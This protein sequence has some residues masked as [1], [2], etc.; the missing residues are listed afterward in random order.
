MTDFRL[1]CYLA[2]VWLLISRVRIFKHCIYPERCRVG[3]ILETTTEPYLK[4]WRSQGTPETT[5]VALEL[6]PLSSEP[7][8]EQDYWNYLQFGI[9]PT[10]Q[11]PLFFIPAPSQKRSL[12][13]CDGSGTMTVQHQPIALI[14]D[15][16]DRWGKRSQLVPTCI[17]PGSLVDTTKL[18]LAIQ[19]VSH[20]DQLYAIEYGDRTAEI[21]VLKIK[22]ARSPNST[23]SS[24]IA[25]A[26]FKPLL[27][28]SN[29]VPVMLKPIG[30]QM[31]A[32]VLD[33]K[34]NE[35]QVWRLEPGN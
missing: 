12:D 10:A 3:S 21:S 2:I 6:T 34:T 9:L 17:V 35:W 23:P 4:I 16:P 28:V 8:P 7:D 32:I 18:S 13:R 20:Q 1:L 31:G 29:P 14:F 24:T 27:Q 30:D 26:F 15:Q 25:Q 11:D 22:E 19:L 5:E 33:A